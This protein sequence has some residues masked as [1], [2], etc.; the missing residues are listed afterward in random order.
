MEA[1][2]GPGTIVAVLLTVG[3]SGLLILA[4]PKHAHA[5]VQTSCS[6]APRLQ[7]EFSGHGKHLD[8]LLE[9][10]CCG[11]GRSGGEG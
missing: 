6:V 8:V 10:C 4:K 5:A 1:K 11:E 3:A 9:L 2:P 7:Y